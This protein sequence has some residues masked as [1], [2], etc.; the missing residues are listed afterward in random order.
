M[1]WRI[2]A[3][4]SKVRA[5]EI[6]V[7]TSFRNLADTMSGPD[8]LYGLSFS[9]SFV[10]PFIVTVISG[11]F[12]LR[13]DNIVGVMASSLEKTLI[14][15]LFNIFAFTLSSVWS[16]PLLSLRGDTPIFSHFLLF[17]NEKNIFGLFFKYGE[18]QSLTYLL[19]ARLHSFLDSLVK[20][21]KDFQSDCNPVDVARL[22]ALCFLRMY[23][24]QVRVTQG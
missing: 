19:Y 1:L 5:G 17:I 8:A 23:C 14:N 21:L 11:M 6:S 3:L 13:V 18:M 12:R 16:L 24:L 20:V 2:D 22:Y 15:C 7:A 10:T 4:N 9:R